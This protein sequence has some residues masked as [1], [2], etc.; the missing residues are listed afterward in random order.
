MDL[1]TP[2]MLHRELSRFSARVTACVTST[3]CT[4][5]ETC[6]HH[7]VHDVW[8]RTTG[9]VVRP[10][11]A[12]TTMVRRVPWA[13]APHVCSFQ[14]LRTRRPH[15]VS[16]CSRRGDLR[17]LAHGQIRVIRRRERDPD[18]DSQYFR[19]VV[20]GD[21]KYGDVHTKPASKVR[22]SKVR[23]FESSKMGKKCLGLCHDPA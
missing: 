9:N 18:G 4:T 8:K 13:F 3:T 6:V 5:C 10:V 12:T 16:S 21:C 20:R 2:A 23:K 15:R 1:R 22:N 19:G 17:S 7:R 11:M 14:S